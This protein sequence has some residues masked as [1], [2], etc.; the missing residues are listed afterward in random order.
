VDV[1]DA[2]LRALGDIREPVVLDTGPCVG[3]CMGVMG[4]STGLRE[5]V[6]SRRR[7]QARR[8]VLE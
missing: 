3:A 4:V 2:S 6:R 5:L 8:L 1:A 7:W